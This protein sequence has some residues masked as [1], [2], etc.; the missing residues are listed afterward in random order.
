M[1]VN[2]TLTRIGDDTRHGKLTSTKSASPE[3]ETELLCLT[4]GLS[5][6]EFAD[7]F[8]LK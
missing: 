5:R 8:S 2:D 4:N 1:E 6:F 7:G 3:L